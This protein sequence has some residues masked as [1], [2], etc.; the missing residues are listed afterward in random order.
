MITDKEL[1][2][3]YRIKRLQRGVEYILLLTLFIFFLVAFYHY[4]RFV[5]IL[6]L[7]LIFFGFNLQLTKQRERR[8][9]APKTSR[10][11]LITDMIESILFLL[12]IFLMSFPTLFGT[13]FGSTPQEHYAV[14]A[15]ILCGI[16]LGGLVGE[17]RFQLRAFLALSLD[18]QENYIYNLKRSIIFPYY[19]S[20]PK[21]HE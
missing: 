6:A 16:F 20:R 8:R 13:L 3:F 11:S 1:L 9:T 15:S 18:E 7:A 5:I 19:S 17:M 14:I 4:Y 12:L 21:R 2:K 10:T